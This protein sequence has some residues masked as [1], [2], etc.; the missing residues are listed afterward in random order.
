MIVISTVQ[1]LGLLL[2]IILSRVIHNDKLILT[3]YGCRSKKH[4]A[5]S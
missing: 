5:E 4:E 1:F 3:I 2:I